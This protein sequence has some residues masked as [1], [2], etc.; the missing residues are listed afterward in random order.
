MAILPKRLKKCNVPIVY[1]N[2]NCLKWVDE[3]KYL[4]IF[5]TNCC[6]RDKRQPSL[7]QAC[8]VTS[9]VK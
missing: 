6:D 5:I 8:Y 3:D 2:Q 9:L 1:L 7:P 4:G